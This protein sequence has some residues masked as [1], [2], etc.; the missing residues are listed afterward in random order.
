MRYADHLHRDCVAGGSTHHI[1]GRPISPRGM[2][3][4]RGSSNKSGQA[5]ALQLIEYKDI[6]RDASS[7][8]HHLAVT[9]DVKRHSPP[10]AMVKVTV[11]RPH[12][13][14]RQA[15][16][17]ATASSVETSFAPSPSPYSRA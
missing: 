10:N 15:P 17:A 5:N 1:A 9:G 3:N 12:A 2:G 14:V 16:G 8:R 7:I 13:D 4:Q 11:R 6:F